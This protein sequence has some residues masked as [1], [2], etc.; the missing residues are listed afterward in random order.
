MIEPL[1]LKFRF[2][3]SKIKVEVFIKIQLPDIP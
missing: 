1:I 3:K 2:S